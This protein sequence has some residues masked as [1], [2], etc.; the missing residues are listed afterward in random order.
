MVAVKV[1]ESLRLEDVPLV[2]VVLSSDAS[3]TLVVALVTDCVTVVTLPAAV[4]L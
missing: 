2:E 4:A 3:A 1:T